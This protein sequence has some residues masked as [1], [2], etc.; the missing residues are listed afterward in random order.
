[1]HLQVESPR[2]LGR[3]PSCLR[4]LI[5]YAEVDAVPVIGPHANHFICVHVVDSPI[6][7][8]FTKN[9]TEES[10]QSAAFVCSDSYA[11]ATCL[12][13]VQK[14]THL[15]LGLTEESGLQAV[16]C[17]DLD[18]CHSVVYSEN[19]LM[20]SR[21]SAAVLVRCLSLQGLLADTL[22]QFEQH[23]PQASQLGIY[24]SQSGA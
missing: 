4:V 20:Q 6:H 14:V 13:E 17:L 12:A 8:G 16:S 24:G 21:Q 7:I 15:L 22:A 1:M 3:S 18:V 9:I 5:L 10:R 2:T 23:P 19:T 11:F